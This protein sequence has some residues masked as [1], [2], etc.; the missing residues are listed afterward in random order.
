MILVR[1]YHLI[2]AMNAMEVPEGEVNCEDNH[3]RL[4]GHQGHRNRA[5]AAAHGNH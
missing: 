5:A 2:E 3:R 1:I 4:L